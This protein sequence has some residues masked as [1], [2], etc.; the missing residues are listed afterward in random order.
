MGWVG[1]LFPFP[2]WLLFPPICCFPK[3]FKMWPHLSQLFLSLSKDDFVPSALSPSPRALQPK[4][5]LL[6]MAFSCVPVPEPA[7]P[8]CLLFGTSKPSLTLTL[9]VPSLLSLDPVPLVSPQDIIFQMRV[10]TGLS[11][12]HRLL[13]PW[14]C[15]EPCL[16]TSCASSNME[17]MRV[18]S[19]TCGS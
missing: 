6:T 5:R 8:G 2:Q 19:C 11:E 4:A 10:L 17:A 14:R 12:A 9:T 7:S 3:G 18:S 16:L 1:R 15:L 13:L